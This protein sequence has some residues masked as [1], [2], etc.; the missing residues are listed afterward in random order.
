MTRQVNTAG[1]QLV[2]AF[3][4]L[5]LLPYKCSAGIPTIGFGTTFYEDG[6]KVSMQ[7]PQ[8]TEAHAEQLLMVHLNTFASKVEKLLKVNVTDNQFA[9]LLAFAYNVG[10][11][12]LGGSTLLKKL[13]TQDYVGAAGEFEKWNKAQGQVLAGLT[14][15]RQAEKALFLHSPSQKTSTPIQT[16]SDLP[17]ADDIEAKLRA[18]EKDIL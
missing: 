16:D 12:A 3:E 17:T 18:I 7:D 8:I 6:R 2:K 5:K 1:V 13:N 11:G 14:R 15:R 10:P 4:G 9:A